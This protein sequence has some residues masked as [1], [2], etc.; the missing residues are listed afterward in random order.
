MARNRPERPAALLPQPGA[1]RPAPPRD[2][3]AALRNKRYRA[4]TKVGR[5]ILGL[6]IDEY[7]IVSALLASNRLTEREA[8]DRCQVAREVSL[9]LSEWAG[10]WLP[11]A[12]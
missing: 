6:E 10:Q 1:H 5:V 3:R 2:R 11:E 12:E 7:R 8:L 4:R 9:L